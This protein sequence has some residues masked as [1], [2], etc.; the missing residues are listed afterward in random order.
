MLTIEADIYEYVRMSYV[1]KSILGPLV[2][3]SDG[4]ILERSIASGLKGKIPHFLN[5]DL[6]FVIEKAFSNGS[7]TTE[8]NSRLLTTKFRFTKQNARNDL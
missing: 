3:I 4:F 8:A 6:M 5:P 1:D 2:H 7:L